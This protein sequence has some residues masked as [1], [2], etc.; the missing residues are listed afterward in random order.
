MA[1]RFKNNIDLNGVRPEIVMAAIVADGIYAIHGYECVITSVTE[2][3]HKSG[4]LHHAGL[5]M[6]LRTRHLVPG[7]EDLIVFD[8]RSALGK[9]FDVM[10]EKTHIHVE[11]QP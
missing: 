1:L 3:K 9:Q 4:S 8:L 5:A 7:D 11:Y 6:D 10:L 2:G